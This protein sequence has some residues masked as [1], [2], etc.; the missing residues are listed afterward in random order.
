M[1]YA[2]ITMSKT[3]GKFPLLEHCCYGLTQKMRFPCEAALFFSAL[4][5][6]KKNVRFFDGN[7]INEN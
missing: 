2:I 5:K 6:E 3:Q 7:L 1:T 4:K